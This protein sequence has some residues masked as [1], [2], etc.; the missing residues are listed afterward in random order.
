MTFD[1][2]QYTRDSL[3]KELYLMELHAKDGSAVEGGCS[4]IQEKHLI[5]IEGLAQEG[6]TLA[7]EPEEKKF[8]ADLADYA[9]N[10]RK[11]ILY[12]DWKPHSHVLS[13]I[14]KAELKCCGSHGVPYSQCS[15]NP[16]LECKA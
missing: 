9:R 7:N 3:A 12:A 1:G 13:C 10:K 15:C 16:S 4:C 14:E 6:V 2:L 11:K 5:G 8:Y